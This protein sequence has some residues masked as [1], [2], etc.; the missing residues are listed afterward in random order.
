MILGDAV[1]ARPG[2][3]GDAQ[4]P[5][6]DIVKAWLVDAH[7]VEV[8]LPGSIHRM[9]VALDMFLGPRSERSRD[10]PLHRRKSPPSGG[11]AFERLSSS[12]SPNSKG[13]RC[14]PTSL[15]LQTPKS[16]LAQPAANLC[17]TDVLSPD[18]VPYFNKV[19]GD[20]LA[21]SSYKLN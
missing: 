20:A 4:S 12:I 18:L 16:G 19:C 10:K 17:V 11:T 8:A 14:Y 2:I 6:D 21:M 9:K 13:S 7:T 5:V 3:P 1:F 15:S